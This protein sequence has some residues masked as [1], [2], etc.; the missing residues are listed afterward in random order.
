MLNV[1]IIGAGA[2]ADAHIGSLLKFPD[3]C[4]ITALAD[5]DPEKASGKLDHFGL[6]AAV[7]ADYQELLIHESPDLAIVLTP[8]FAHAEIAI[9]A[10]NAGAHVLL[11]KPM[12]TSLEACDA[13]LAAAEVN[14]KL[15]SVMAPNRFV[16]PFVK[17]KSVID[18]GLAG[19]I[20]HIQVD[21]LWWRGQ[22][23]YDLWW[24]GS[25]EKEGGGCTLNH[26]IHHIDLLL[27]IAGMPAEVQS[28][29]AN[30][31]HENSG[32]EDFSSTMLL[33]D[34]GRVGQITASLVHHGDNHRLIF[35]GE[36]ASIAVSWKVQACS[37]M[38]NGFPEGNIEL[39]MEIN[40][41][42][43]QLPNEPFEGY[44]GQI[45]NVL[46]AIAGENVLL[47]DG[48]AGRRAVEF[49]MAIYQSGTT[50]KRVRLPMSPE[51]I[52]Y[53]REA[54]LRNAPHFREINNS[55]V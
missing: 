12:A 1:A 33:Y 25:W 48:V 36:R 19:K 55:V 35:Q 21:S 13:I 11:E 44:D 9:A 41:F 15:L 31:N 14:G 54:I 5:I 39:E 40:Q 18:S 34:D 10:L 4:Q 8:P 26:A 37:A 42:Y 32:V 20:L 51:D 53:T 50:G 23:Y 3:Q 49:V 46:G 16:S 2:I 22:N 24:R 43:D 47:A 30:I 7:Y 17:L 27:W 28:V 45:A 52:F 6:Q 38:D 29:I